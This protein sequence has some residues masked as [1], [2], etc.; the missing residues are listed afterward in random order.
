MLSFAKQVGEVDGEISKEPTIE[1][2]T[3]DTNKVAAQSCL[4]SGEPPQPCNPSRP[5][6]P[7]GPP[8][9]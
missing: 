5:S 1:L 8:R 9:P 4:P 7:P 2:V 3:L 6:P